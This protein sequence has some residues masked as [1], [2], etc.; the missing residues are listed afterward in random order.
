MIKINFFFVFFLIL[1]SYTSKSQYF[2]IGEDPAE[3]K[4]SYIKTKNFK[5]I[6]PK[7]FE[8]EAQILINKLEYQN[9][10]IGSSLKGRH[11]RLPIILHNR[12]IVSNGVSVY[13]PRRIELFTNPPSNT[14]PQ[15]WLDQLIIHESRHIKQIDYFRKKTLGALYYL[16]GE[17]I[18]GG[19]I[20]FTIPQWFFEGDAVLSETLLSKS[21]RGRT[22]NF[23][24][25]LRANLFRNK[26][27][28]SY[29]KSLYG[30][31]KEPVADFYQQGYNIVKYSKN[32]LGFNI[33]NK[34]LEQIAKA[35]FKLNPFSQHFKISNKRNIR[36]YYK[37]L[38]IDIKNKEIERIED[39]KIS[40][41]QKIIS[42]K[43]KKYSS[44]S[45][46]DILNDSVIISLKQTLKSPT[47]LVLIK[48]NIENTLSFNSL[49]V[50]GSLYANDNKA[51]WCEYEF[52]PRWGLASTIAIKYF[53]YSENKIKK[54]TNK[55]RYQSPSL[56]KS[57]EL[58]AVTKNDLQNINS[59]DIIDFE[60][61]VKMS[62]NS[63]D[64]SQIIKPLW[65]DND[66]AIISIL[67]NENGKRIAKYSFE[68]K[69][70]NDLTE[71]TFND[72]QLYQV[73]QDKII[74]TIPY[75]QNTSVFEY[76][77]TNNIFSLIGTREFGIIKAK[78]YNDNSLLVSE[79]TQD[80]NKICMIDK[81]QKPQNIDFK[82]IIINDTI[83]DNL[84]KNETIIDF[85]N[86]NDSIYKV[87]NYKKILHLFK[88]HSW[89]PIYIDTENSTANLGL[90]IM[91]HNE[92]STSFFNTG[93]K[94]SLAEQTT[95]F[96][97]QYSYRGLIP[98]IEASFETGGRANYINFN[99]KDIRYE[100]HQ[101][102]LVIGA[103]IPLVYNKPSFFIPINV[104][105][106]FINNNLEY[107]DKFKGIN[108]L[109]SYFYRLQF[110]IST[111]ILKYKAH[112]DLQPPL[113]ILLN[114]SYSKI[115]GTINDELYVLQ[116][117]IFLPSFIKNHGFNFYIGIQ[118]SYFE[119]IFDG[120]IKPARGLYVSNYSNYYSISLNYNFPIFYPDFSIDDMLYLKRIRGNI[121]YDATGN[122]KFN[123]FES[124]G[125]ELI[126][127]VHLFKIVS[128]FS[129]GGRYLLDINDNKLVKEFIFGFNIRN[130]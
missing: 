50:E 17:Q 5:L 44:Y 98:V 32:Q 112:R 116:S 37:K 105:T 73:Y 70:W 118:S 63:P 34:N 85:K 2:S 66:T 69:I 81:F 62:I 60:G 117:N 1:Y 11:R 89:G 19:Y 36:D 91:S 72:M 20:G 30:S 42:Q 80:G 41:L 67:L 104:F 76:S 115:F 113:G 28:I 99:N 130:Y 75:Q 31:Y 47:K 71:P 96:K 49:I 46:F 86:I 48:N 53:D 107:K 33:W 122:K 68:N 103:N 57:G 61:N 92:L 8:K 7:E 22:P 23:D 127:D 126:T 35:P 109:N 38:M 25:E 106:R 29:T 114:A 102:D 24:A 16:F 40:K 54:I 13:A 95:R 14:Y 26:K 83:L 110:G 94:Y 108:F 27:V 56:S 78:N 101:N 79:I 65:L 6:F 125:I 88:I 59:I 3:V 100:W 97:T 111:G 18:I 74:L 124:A 120:M 129:I 55:T 52:N 123:S 58:I 10:Y 43:S 77:I 121:F 21:G 4:W 39:T 93:I 64:K 128:P 12:T 45:D 51:L 82:D 15:P 90:S 87:K 119:N 84:A 9:Q